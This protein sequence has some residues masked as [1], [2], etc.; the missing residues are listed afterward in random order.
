MSETMAA[1]DIERELRNLNAILAVSKAMSSEVQLNNSRQ[2]A[3]ATLQPVRVA[4]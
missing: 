2:G 4:S 3:V 1:V